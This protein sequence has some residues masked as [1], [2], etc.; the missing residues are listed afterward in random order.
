MDIFSFPPTNYTFAPKQSLLHISINKHQRVLNN[1]IFISRFRY[2]LV[3]RN[4]SNLFIL[5]IQI[6]CIYLI[7]FVNLFLFRI[8]GGFSGCLRS[9]WLG[10]NLGSFLCCILGSLLL[11]VMRGLTEGLQLRIIR[12]IMLLLSHHP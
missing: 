12:I 1:F 5:I 2:V 7:H 9:S 4:I 8:Y 10:C 11:L 6:L 3:L